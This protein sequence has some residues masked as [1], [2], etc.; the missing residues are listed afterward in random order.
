MTATQDSEIAIR[1]ADHGFRLRKRIE[2]RDVHWTL[3]STD[4]TPDDQFVV[5]T[6]LS[7]TM[8]LCN[9][10]G[11]YELH[12]DLPLVPGRSSHHFG[13]LCSKINSQGREI[14]AGCS[15]HC[16]AVYDVERKRTVAMLP[17]HRD[18]V[19]TVCFADQTSLPHLI[20]SGS[21]DFLV[22]VWDRRL[23]GG[24]DADAD[25]TGEGRG[26]SEAARAR[27]TSRRALAGVFPGHIS[28][29]TSVSPR[30]DGVYVLS[31]AKDQTAKLWDLR[32]MVPAAEFE[33]SGA[34][35]VNPFPWDYRYMEWPGWGQKFKHPNDRSVMTYR[36]H[37]VQGTLIRAHISPPASTGQ[38]FVYSG[39]AVRCGRRKDRVKIEVAG[40]SG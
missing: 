4:I 32:T 40:S 1:D 39:S 34:H 10:A 15:N 28:G 29:L 11:A 2:P 18:D 6:T 37:T 19:N 17:A 31:N 9:V 16:I 21:D 33:A 26:A 8:H 24:G 13:V 7:S 14:V 25:T 27:A 12:E 22:K 23:M 30:G 3:S 5:Y 36:G 38:A 20:V 35:E